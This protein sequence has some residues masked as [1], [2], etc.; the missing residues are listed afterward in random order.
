VNVQK[1]FGEKRIPKWVW[2]GLAAL[3]AIQV[4]YV[5]EMLAA[6]IIFAV[7]FGFGATIAFVLFLFDQASQKTVEWAE[8][9]AKRAAQAARRGVT[10]LEEEISKKL[11]HKPVGA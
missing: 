2:I 10:H 7:L 11:P 1:W 8:P 6:L 4:Y 5:R 3:V 9:Q